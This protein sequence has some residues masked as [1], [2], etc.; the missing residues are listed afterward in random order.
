MS[1]SH[2]LEAQEVA[3]VLFGL[4]ADLNFTK[5][6]GGQTATDQLVRLCHIDASSHV[7]DVGCGVGITPSNLGKSVGC[8]VTGIDLRPGMIRRARERATSLT[9]KTCRSATTS[10]TWSWPNLSWRSSETSR[11]R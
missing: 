6:L 5:H 4:Q 3:E 10:S 2:S 11:G 7:L 1:E 9:S 8:A